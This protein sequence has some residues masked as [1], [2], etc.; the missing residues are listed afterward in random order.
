MKDVIA[1]DYGEVSSAVEMKR[2]V[3]DMW[4]QFSNNQWDNLIDSMSERMEAVIA[5][6]GGSTRYQRIIQNSIVVIQYSCIKSMKFMV[7][8]LFAGINGCGG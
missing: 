2:I 3:W 7:V 5:A 8:N 4:G 1:K 6:K